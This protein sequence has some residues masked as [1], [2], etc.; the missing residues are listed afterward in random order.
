MNLN[1]VANMKKQ[2]KANNDLEL[3]MLAILT[4]YH[5]EGPGPRSMLI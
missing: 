5:D 2:S 1:F 3:K 4:R